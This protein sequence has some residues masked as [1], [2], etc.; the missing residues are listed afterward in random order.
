MPQ[1]A[2]QS[3]IVP[4]GLVEVPLGG[5]PPAQNAV[6]LVMQ[7]QN[8]T[9]WCWAAVTASV[10]T[11]YRNQGWTQCRVANQLLGQTTCCVSGSSSACNEPWYLDQALNR[12]GDLNNYVAVA[13]SW[14]QIQSEI[15]GGHPIGVRIGWA[16][17]GGHFVALSGYTNGGYV[18]VQDPWFGPSPQLYTTFRS[19]YQGS[20][21]WTHSYRTIPPGG[22]N[23]VATSQPAT[24]CV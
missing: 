24:Q 3:S 20:G 19:S 16:G 21:V 9:Q 14:N 13:L 15:D 22:Q 12:V 11:F 8:Q 23:A 4:L 2:F 6:A 10:A 7:Q 17:G 5:A 1:S 18:E